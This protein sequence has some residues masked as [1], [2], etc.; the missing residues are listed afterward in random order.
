MKTTIISFFLILIAATHIY[1]QGI[2]YGQEFLI[3]TNIY[4]NPGNPQIAAS[5]NGNFLVCWMND[6]P[7]RTGYDVVGQLFD[8][9]GN[10]IGSE[11]RVNTSSQ[12][13]QADH[14]VAARNDGG[15]VVCW[16]SYEGDFGVFGQLVD[17]NGNKKGNEFKVNTHDQGNVNQTGV[18]VLKNG[19]FVVC[20]QGEH[21]LDDST[22]GIFAQTFNASGAK[23]GTEF[24]V[25]TIT[26][27]Q[28][29]LPTIA[30]LSGGG[31][32]VCW[33]E[34]GICGQ[35]FNASGAKIGSQLQ[36]G[37]NDEFYLLRPAI[38]G[39]TNGGFVACWDV[40]YWDDEKQNYFDKHILGQLF[41][42]AGNKKS[43]EF[44]VNT[45]YTGS[46]STVINLANG[47]FIVCWCYH[48]QANTDGEVF[49]Q[50]FTE[51]G[52]M[53]WNEFQ[54]NSYTAGVQAPTGVASSG[55]AG[56]VVCWYGF[57]QDGCDPGIVGKR[58]PREPMIQLLKE[59][60]LISPANDQTIDNIHPAFRW[61]QPG[62]TREC[63][64][65]EITFNLYIDTD[66]NFSKPQIIK[67]IQDTTYTIDSLAAGKTYFWK[68]LAK[69][70]AGD[71]LWSKQQDWGFFIKPGATLVENAENELPQ[72]FELFQ[73]C[74]N[75]FNST[76]EI[77]YSLP[78]GMDLYHVTIKIYD[79]RGRLV[80]VLVDQPQS[81]GVHSVKWSGLDLHNSPV[82]SGVYFYMLQVGNY[83]VTK[84]LLLLE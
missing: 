48:N 6:D 76:T 35:L 34:P 72:D 44:Q 58:F 21:Y 20:W 12:G 41:D 80:T 42:A 22:W 5:Q 83:Q 45:S 31:F 84:K 60:S 51:T 63:Y 78:S 30:A 54:I 69:N 39:L 62:F 8:V 47:R 28:Q 68:V 70:L 16:V 40:V 18:A 65:Y 66:I 74:P 4:D 64:S 50:L 9:N 71:S 82:A 49:G 61:Q 67:N 15:F 10:K 7:D 19:D 46:A 56:F 53:I 32:V 11:F 57:Y 3:N 75:P 33:V 73:N 13:Y 17:A 2:P 77:R 55:E 14:S 1:S 27:G 36:I 23:K 81:P 24:Q 52:Q 26:D 29:G 59:F 25:N 38:A 43:D 37:T 79:I